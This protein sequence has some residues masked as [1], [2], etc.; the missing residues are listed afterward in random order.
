M[1]FY[2]ILFIWSNIKIKIG[3]TSI[4]DIILGI[5]PI[6]LLIIVFFLDKNIDSVP[7]Q[8]SVWIKNWE[9]LKENN[10]K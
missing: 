6:S 5:L 10:I 3:F 9:Q 4:C 7:K 1:V 8:K 2:H